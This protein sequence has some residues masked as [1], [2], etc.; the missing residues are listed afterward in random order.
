MRQLFLFTLL[1][2]S[3][4]STLS[5]QPPLPVIPLKI[6]SGT[7][8][9]QI[10][11]EV[12]ATEKTR[13][14]GLMDRKELCANCG[15]LLAWNKPIQTGMWM[16]NTHIPLDML[17]IREDEIV[18]I[19]PNAKPL[20]ETVIMSPPN[21]TAVLEVNAGWAGLNSITPGWHVN[22]SRPE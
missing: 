12:A 14:S 13:Q 17:F 21:I 18:A 6:T 7:A 9:L 16:R 2:T 11:A 3:A 10:Q 8:T 20:D 19:H 15:M 4:V 5:A 22:G 1:C